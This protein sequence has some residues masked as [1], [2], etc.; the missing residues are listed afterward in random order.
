VTGASQGVGAAVAVALAKSGLIVCAL[1][2]RC[3]L[4]YKYYHNTK[5]IS[6][7]TIINSE[8]IRLSN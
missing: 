6:R 3:G 8:R 4:S 7:F 2:K 1:A 5:L